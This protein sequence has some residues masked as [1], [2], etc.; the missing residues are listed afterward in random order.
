MALTAGFQILLNPD[1]K[2]YRLK[3]RVLSDGGPTWE[4]HYFLYPKN[5]IFIRISFRNSNI[6]SY[7]PMHRFSS[8]C[9][10]EAI[11]T[12]LVVAHKFSHLP[13]ANITNIKE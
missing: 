8:L 3:T 13:S 7:G 9:S 10:A 2:V 5:Q 1:F 12:T 6:R 11:R 4:T